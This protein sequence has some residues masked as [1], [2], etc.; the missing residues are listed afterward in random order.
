MSEIK[1]IRK[2]DNKEQQ[3]YIERDYVL[4]IVRFLKIYVIE[5]VLNVKF[6]TGK[7]P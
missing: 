7:R 5:V 3:D 2:N 6:V 1:I 4:Q